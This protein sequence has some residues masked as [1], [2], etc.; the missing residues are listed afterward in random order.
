MAS[1]DVAMLAFGGPGSVAEVGRFI[2]TMTGA[3]PAPE[4][5]AAVTRRYEAIGGRSPLPDITARQ[6]AAL[7]AAMVAQLGVEVRVRPGYL[8]SSPSVADC[9]A[10]LD[11]RDTAVLPMSPF[12]SRFTT[13]AYRAALAAAGRP[14]LS[15]VEG[16]H[17]DRRYLAAVSRR[18]HETLDGADA[19][20]FAVLFTA[21]NVP[22][23][24]VAEGDPYVEQLQQ[25][26]AQL[27]PGLMPGDWRLAFQSKGRRGGEW[28]EPEVVPAVHDL[29]AAGWKNL[30]VVPLGFVAD[31]VET[32]YDLDVE[33]R[34]VA[35]SSG[36]AFLRSRAL[37]DAPFFIEALADI[38]IE[39][40][41]RRPLT[42]PV[43]LGRGGPFGPGGSLG[44]GDPFGAD[45]SPEPGNGHGA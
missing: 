38:V 27:L 19:S 35:E 28:L 32:L 43:D 20:E 16:W 29:A 23:E 33:L 18:L 12:S 6:A 10:E 22:F 24:T 15:F 45:D 44:F 2:E 11:P 4:T 41:A 3:A 7:Q 17:A 42:G 30:L 5:L 14:E 13:G 8:Y 21:H 9:L 26:V 34:D 39:H 40:L 25:T 31:H 1:I 37:N 36:M